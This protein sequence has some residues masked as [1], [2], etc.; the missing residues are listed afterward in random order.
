MSILILMDVNHTIQGDRT[1]HC[2]NLETWNTGVD[3]N[4]N[5]VLPLLSLPKIRSHII[6]GPTH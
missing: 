1:T 6:V 4:L 3:A 2:Q 5:Y